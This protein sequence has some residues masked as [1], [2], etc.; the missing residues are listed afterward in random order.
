M[1]VVGYGGAGSTAA[2]TAH[3]NGASV[4]ILEKMPLGG[5]NTKA[6]GGTILTP[7]G[8]EA[9]QYL[10][11]V[12]FGTVERDIIETFVENAIK[13]GDWVREIGGEVAVFQPLQVSYPMAAAGASW[14]TV[15]YSESM[16]KLVV[17]GAEEETDAE[18]L[19]KLLSS[20]VERRGIKVMT[21]TRAEELIT[22]QEGEVV[23]AIAQSEGKRVSIKAKRAVILT[24]GGFEYDEALKWDFLPLKPFYALGNQGNTGDG[25]RIGQRIGAALW[26][27]TAT[28]A[29][30]GFKVPEY[31]AA[32][33][34]WFLSERFIYTDKY[35]RRFVNEST[36]E[37]TVTQYNEY[38]RVGRDTDFDRSRETLVSINKPPYY[39][40]KLWP[41]LINTQGGLRRDKE[42]RVLSCEGKPIPRLYA[43]GELGS[44]WGFLYQGAGNIGECLVFGR[45]AGRN[46]AAERSWS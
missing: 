15:P 29:C 1:V 12:N 8:M 40:I 44:I 19:W 2:I 13:N 4:I 27:M 35:G 43:A 18:H 39:A 11:T 38:C 25:I 26:H 32:F 5:G 20:N 9:V 3:D 31:E 33:P 22:N 21:N 14:P 34:I 24:C 28:S 45:I 23:G 41:A 10:E 17:K 7:K 42:A 30:L 16:A 37:R 6:S 46:A 36:L